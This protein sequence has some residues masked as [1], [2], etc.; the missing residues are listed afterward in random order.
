MF[1]AIIHCG[2]LGA[3]KNHDPQYACSHPS[4]L[5]VDPGSYCDLRGLMAVPI[6]VRG[7]TVTPF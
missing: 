1:D 6:R 2:E 5:Q 3:P 4:H 7:G